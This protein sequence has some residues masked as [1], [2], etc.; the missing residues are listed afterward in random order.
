VFNKDGIY[1]VN[2][3]SQVL[4]AVP[5]ESVDQAAHAKGEPILLYTNS[6][7]YNSPYTSIEPKN[8]TISQGSVDPSYEW[9]NSIYDI[10]KNLPFLAKDKI[11]YKTRMKVGNLNGGS[12]GWGFWN[13]N[14]DIFAMD[15]VWF[16]QM[17]G[18]IPGG[19][20]NKFYA[21]T[22]LK[23]HPLP[24]LDEEWHDYEITIT[25]EKIEFFIDGVSVFVETD[26]KNI[27]SGPM[28]F[29]N[30]VDNSVFDVK[31]LGKK[32]L[33]ET[34]GPKSNVC[35]YMEIVV[36]NDS[37][38]LGSII[39]VYL[40]SV[41]EAVA[42]VA[43][44]EPSQSPVQ[45]PD[46]DTL[47]TAAGNLE[48]SETPEKDMFIIRSLLG[49]AGSV[50]DHTPFT[51]SKTTHQPAKLT[52]PKDHHYHPN[53]GREWYWMGTHMNV[54]DQ[55]GN[56]GRISVMMCILKIRSIGIDSQ[57]TAGWTDRETLIAN[58]LTTITVD[59]GAGNKKIYRRNPNYQWVA[60]GGDLDF[61]TPV[62]A[63]GKENPF[64]FKCG[65][66]SIKGSVD[67]MPLKVVMMMGRICR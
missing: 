43:V 36:G 6:E 5:S 60:I 49:R 24:P 40:N 47:Y 16:L 39:Q 3:I 1:L 50:G 66:D 37:S 67:V 29:H 26:S 21:Q 53:M 18:D 63:A 38:S 52:F 55:K 2:T 58:N 44:A 31:E 56:Y 13:T 20:T 34:S 32:I 12:R 59:M 57:T 9:Y 4:P 33:Q 25:P 7:I 28:A 48:N 23:M 62:D 8:V 54:K 30:W 11:T 14:V 15:V 45:I 27:P 61:S 35:E 42:N 19:T 64:F 46:F 41:K 17:Q 22:Q 10:F 51:A 65:P